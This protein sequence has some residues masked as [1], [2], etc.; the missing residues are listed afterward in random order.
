MTHPQRLLGPSRGECSGRTAS[1]TPL[2]REVGGAIDRRVATHT[3]GCLCEAV[4]FEVAE[5]LTRIEVCHCSRCRRSY[6]VGFAA[7]VY[8][9]S[10]GFSWTRGRD[11]VTAY[12]APLRTSPPAYRHTFCARCGSPLPIVRDDF[13]FVEIPVGTLDRTPDRPPAYE[14]F[15]R[16]KPPWLPASVAGR[17]FDAAAPRAEH[18][19][20][21]LAG[22][23][24]R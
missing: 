9:R 8:A 13:G 3:G 11:A 6:G 24:D 14:I 18:V 22:K 2:A 16:S 1:R 23:R 17:S 15:A 5:P 12:D 19:A 4:R 21:E 7:T 20:R 10:A